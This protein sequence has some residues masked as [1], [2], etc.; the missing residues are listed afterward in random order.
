MTHPYNL[1]YIL[2]YG[3]I[4]LDYSMLTVFIK[5]EIVN[6]Y[7][8]KFACVMLPKIK[9]KRVIHLILKAMC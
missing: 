1:D 2:Y 4:D 9:Y 6:L 8:F 7:C 5:K 3:H